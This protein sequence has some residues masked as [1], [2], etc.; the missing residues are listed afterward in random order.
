MFFHIQSNR[1]K[2]RRD[3]SGLNM[4]FP[5]CFLSKHTALV[6]K[7]FFRSRNPGDDLYITKSPNVLNSFWR[8]LLEP[9]PRSK[10]PPFGDFW[11]L[12]TVFVWEGLF[13]KKIQ[14]P[15]TLAPTMC[16]FWRFKAGGTRRP[17]PTQT[18]KFRPRRHKLHLKSRS[19]LYHNV[20]PKTI[21][22]RRR[23]AV[24]ALLWA[25]LRPA[26]PVKPASSKHGKQRMAFRRLVVRAACWMMSSSILNS[27]RLVK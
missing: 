5:K 10:L 17:Y 19:I 24:M 18:N 6:G 1:N 22:V 14:P 13:K 23:E 25:F 26:K 8:I 20:S 16:L 9:F 11:W 15:P 2:T 27:D 21:D 4:N 3:F 7:D 12:T